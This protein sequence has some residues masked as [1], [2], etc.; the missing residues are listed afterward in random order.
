MSPHQPH[1]ACVRLVSGSVPKVISYDDLAAGNQARWEGD[2]L[3][4]EEENCPAMSHLDAAEQRSQEI[5]RTI[6]WFK[7]QSD[8][9]IARRQAADDLRRGAADADALAST[10]RH[11]VPNCLGMCC[12]ALS[13][14][15]NTCRLLPPRSCK[16]R[17]HSHGAICNRKRLT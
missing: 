6:T 13:S 3:F 8:R 4:C 7:T 1:A 16:E 5:E 9:R 2:V 14:N 11:M 10:L 17:F 15:Y 12:M